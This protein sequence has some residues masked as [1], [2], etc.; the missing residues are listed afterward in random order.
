MHGAC[1]INTATQRAETRIRRGLF[2]N[3]PTYTDM[4]DTVE[5]QVPKFRL[6]GAGRQCKGGY[7][8]CL[9]GNNEDRRLLI[10]LRNCMP[11]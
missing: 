11:C 4:T 2:R 3:A 7:V 1:P 6:Y 8:Q 9:Y 10:P 5:S